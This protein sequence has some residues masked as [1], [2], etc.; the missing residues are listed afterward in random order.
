MLAQAEYAGH[1]PP[2]RGPGAEPA[3]CA[4]YGPGLAAG[5]MDRTVRRSQ[6]VSPLADQRLLNS[7]R[8]LRTERKCLSAA[9]R[10]LSKSGRPGQSGV[11]RQHTRLCCDKRTGPANP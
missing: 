1:G 3:G 4:A 5:L 8:L 9:R 11:R 6:E 10:L 2:L 7:A